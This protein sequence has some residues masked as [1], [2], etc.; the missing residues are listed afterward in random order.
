MQNIPLQIMVQSKLIKLKILFASVANYGVRKL[1]PSAQSSVQS[2]LMRNQLF[3]TLL[4][5]AKYNFAQ[6]V[7]DYLFPLTY[8]YKINVREENEVI[9]KGLRK[10]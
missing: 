9:K 5:L 6:Q 4:K 2:K 3:C 8:Y 10:V 1:V 7:Q